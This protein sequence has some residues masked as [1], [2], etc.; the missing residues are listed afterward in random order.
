[1]RV[2]N[3]YQRNRYVIRNRAKE[4]YKNDKGRLRD[5]ARVN[6]K[7]HFKKNN[8][9]R[10]NMEEIDIIISLKKRNKN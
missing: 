10:E 4:F 2:T 3:Y 5:N 7:I 6:T 8:I 1:M 9:K